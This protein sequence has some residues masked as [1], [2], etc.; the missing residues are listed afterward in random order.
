MPEL[1]KVES[2]LEWTPKYF[3][4]I[5]VSFVVCLLVSNLAAVKLF[6]LGSAIFSAGILVFPLSYIFG[7]ILSE[8][9]GYRR[10]RRI[11]WMGLLSNL[12]MVIALKIAIVLPPAPNWP[13]QEQFSTI[14][15][16]IPRIVLGSLV[17][18]W[19]GEMIN[20]FIMVKMKV[21]T[22][23]KHL[24][25]RTISSTLAG[26]AVDTCLFALIS[27]AGIIPNDLLFKTI[28][29]AWLFKSLYEAAVTPLTY[30]LVNFLKRAEGVDHFDTKDSFNPIG[31]K[32]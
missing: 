17:G 28:I 24:W 30:I 14:H 12:F 5:A 16:I 15:E 11:I 21:L 22:N 1:K 13:F 8:V 29:S 7:D 3:D 31:L 32:L 25:A 18:Y 2:A 23:G 20:T 6:Q 19:A 9:Y 10:A 4:F 27:F 26:Q